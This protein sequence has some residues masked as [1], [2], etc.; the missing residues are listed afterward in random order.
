VLAV[1]NQKHK[2]CTRERSCTKNASLASSRECV[3]QRAEEVLETSVQHAR[4]S[5]A[6]STQPGL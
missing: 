6:N 5:M 4:C 2:Q 1:T 3:L